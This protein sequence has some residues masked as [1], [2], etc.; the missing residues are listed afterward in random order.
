MFWLL[1]KTEEQTLYIIELQKQVNKLKKKI[2]KIKN[3]LK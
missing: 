3:N 1:Q 2:N